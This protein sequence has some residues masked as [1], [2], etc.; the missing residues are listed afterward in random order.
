[1]TIKRSNKILSTEAE[2]KQFVGIASRPLFEQLLKAGMPVAVLNGRYYA[3]TQNIEE[4]F[5]LKTLTIV[6]K[7]DEEWMFLMGL[8]SLKLLNFADARKY[9]DWIL[10]KY[11]E[12]IP[13][14]SFTPYVEKSRLYISQLDSK[15]SKK[16][17]FKVITGKK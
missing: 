4:W 14:T 15:S 1:M 3:H 16:A 12:E 17:R 10:K 8:V 11:P 13:Q 7:I 9:F 5:R 2:I 6:E